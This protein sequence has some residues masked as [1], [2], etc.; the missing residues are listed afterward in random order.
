LTIPRDPNEIEKLKE[1][2]ARNIANGDW[3]DEV[4]FPGETVPLSPEE[5]VAKKTA[6]HILSNLGERR[7]PK[8]K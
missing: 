1:L 3:G 5:R 7:L 2:A 8:R 6:S 4:T